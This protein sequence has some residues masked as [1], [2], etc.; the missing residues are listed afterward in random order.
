MLAIE[1][2]LHPGR[3]SRLVISNMMRSVPGLQ[4]YA[5]QV[6]MPSMD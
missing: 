1:Y 5:E 6:L 3:T 4:R 2:A